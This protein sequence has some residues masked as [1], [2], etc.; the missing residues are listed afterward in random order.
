MSNRQ[1]LEK[2][3][4]SLL[5]E[6]VLAEADYMLANSNLEHWFA[7]KVKSVQRYGLEIPPELFQ[8]REK[9]EKV[10]HFLSGLAKYL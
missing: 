4:D 7:P 6:L 2:E 5:K 1:E 10:A 8:S 3:S 9:V